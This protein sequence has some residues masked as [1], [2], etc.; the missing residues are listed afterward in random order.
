MLKK[1]SE[2]VGRS[3]GGREIGVH[4]LTRKHAGPGGDRPVRSRGRV[5]AEPS[6]AETAD[7]R[8]GFDLERAPGSALTAI[9]SAA[10]DALRTT[11][12][13]QDS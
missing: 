12:K 5:L 1:T 9:P 13:E 8:S 7:T 11:R 10:Y 4:G 3:T 2:G 6:A